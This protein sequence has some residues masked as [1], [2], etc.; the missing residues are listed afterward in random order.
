MAAHNTGVCRVGYALGTSEEPTVCGDGEATANS[1]LTPG[2]TASIGQ[3][4]SGGIRRHGRGRAEA[5]DCQK[6]FCRGATCRD[7]GDLHQ[8]PWHRNVA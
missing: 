6:A 5:A 7:F 2:M 4:G 8:Y 1:R 3:A